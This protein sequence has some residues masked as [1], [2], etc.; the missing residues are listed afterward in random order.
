MLEAAREEELLNEVEVT[1]LM[2]GHH[3]WQLHLLIDFPHV[4]W[5]TTPSGCR[6]PTAAGRWAR[7]GSAR[8]IAPWAGQMRTDAAKMLT[9]KALHLY[10]AAAAPLEPQNAALFDVPGLRRHFDQRVGAS[11]SA[12]GRTRRRSGRQSGPPSRG[13][14]HFSFFL[15]R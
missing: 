1:M 15:E 12:S 11:A 13:C 14:D 8:R 4:C 3:F 5:P 7:C 2:G 9:P 6:G 10:R